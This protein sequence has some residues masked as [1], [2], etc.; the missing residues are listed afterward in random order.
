[1]S[2]SY[3]LSSYYSQHADCKYPKIQ[4]FHKYDKV[5]ASC[6]EKST[7]ECNPKLT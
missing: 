1:M 3:L 6:L 4:D 2:L 7:K 5:A